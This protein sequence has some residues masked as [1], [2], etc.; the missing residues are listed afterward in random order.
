MSNYKKLSGSKVSFSV[1]IGKEDL[2]KSQKSV[3]ARAKNDVSVKGFR[4][5]QA[6]EDMVIAQIG[7][8]KLA[9]ESLN[10]ALDKAYREFIT[11][12]EIAVISAPETKMPEKQEMPMEVSFEVEVFPEVKMGDYKKVK[13]KKTEVKV[14]DKEVEE[15]LKTVCAQAQIAQSVSRKAK[16]GD[17]LEVDFCGKDKDGKTLPNTD[18]K[19]HKFRIGMGQFLP[20]LEKGFVGMAAGEEK[21]AVKVKFPKQYHA[22]DMAGQTVPFDIKLHNVSEIDSSKLTEEDIEKLSGKKQSLEDFKV[23]VTSTITANKSQGENQKNMDE[24]NKSLAKLVKVDL[25]ESWIEKEIN[26]RIERL[27]QSPQYQH[28][29]ESFWKQIGKTEEIVKKEAKTEGETDLKV[30]LGLSEIVKLEKIELDKDEME[31]AHQMAHQHFENSND[32]NSHAHHA[33][34]DKAI[35]NL[36][37]DKYITSISN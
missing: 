7:P 32:H 24:F 29:P 10:T 34:M 17:L 1:K 18:G 33:E 16:D 14:T 36:K 19:N 11:K 22:P 26:A 2:E 37:I 23:Q 27:K 5:G 3:I 12:E 13:I 31:K 28:D 30:F 20:D 35:L 4:K 9:F 21:K 25:P 6:P 15:V 8:E